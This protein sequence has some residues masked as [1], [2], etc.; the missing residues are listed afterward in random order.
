MKISET[1]KFL[2][3]LCRTIGHDHGKFNRCTRC[4]KKLGFVIWEAC[5]Q[6]IYNPLGVAKFYFPP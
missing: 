3:D 1:K 2:R 6:V 5:G 4:K